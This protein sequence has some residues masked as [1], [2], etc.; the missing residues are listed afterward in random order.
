MPL[1]RR[2]PDV[3][4]GTALLDQGVVGSRDI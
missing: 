1:V 4:L 3:D 2:L